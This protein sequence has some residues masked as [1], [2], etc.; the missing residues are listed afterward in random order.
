MHAIMTYW[1]NE[2][3]NHTM[4]ADQEKKIG[5]QS[6]SASDIPS[7]IFSQMSYI[8]NTIVTPS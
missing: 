4:H 6:V 3:E 2:C 5:K 1:L 8:V 7:D